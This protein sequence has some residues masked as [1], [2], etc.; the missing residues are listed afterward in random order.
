[1]S[2]YTVLHPATFRLDGGAMFGIIPKPLWEGKANP[3]HLNR[4]PL[5]LRLLLL[6]WQNKV[7]LID[8]GIGDYHGEKFDTQF[9]IEGNRNPLRTAVEHANIRPEEITDIILTH[10]HF[11]HVGGLA[12]IENEKVCPVFENAMVHLHHEHY[13]YALNP[14]IRDAGSF[15]IKFFKPLIEFYEKNNQLKWLNGSEGEVIRDGH[16]WLNFKTSHG[17]TPHQIH[18][19]DKEM[20]YMADIIP[21][22][23]HL[24]IPWVMGY[25]IAPG[26]TTEDK[27]ALYPFIIENDLTVIFEHDPKYWGAK[28]SVNEKGRFAWRELFESTQELSQE[29]P[30]N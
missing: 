4:I 16:E 15:Q 27:K 18:P 22:S 28:M 19:Y 26:I 30:E 7:I 12:K 5:D 14:T 11:D 25:D 10:L 24:S 20:I 13:K 17:H 8:S 21:T 23:N 3:D 6:K 9:A 29:L 1:M 2:K